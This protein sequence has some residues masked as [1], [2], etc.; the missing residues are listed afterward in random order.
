MR[1]QRSLSTTWN[2]L[3]PK[4]QRN[5]RQHTFQMMTVF[6]IIV[7]PKLFPVIRGEYKDGVLQTNPVDKAFQL[8]INC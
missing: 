4:D 5:L 7:L 6:K 1:Y 2:T 8:L 3:S